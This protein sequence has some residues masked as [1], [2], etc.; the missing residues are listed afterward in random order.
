MT[1]IER[2]RIKQLLKNTFWQFA[3]EELENIT[4]GLVRGWASRN[5]HPDIVEATAINLPG[6]DFWVRVE[7]TCYL[8]KHLEY[9]HNLTK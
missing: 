6:R 1:I 3:T 7:K 2:N 5:L 4:P 9:W 8:Y